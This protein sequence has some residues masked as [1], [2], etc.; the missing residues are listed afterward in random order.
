MLIKPTTQFGANKLRNRTLGPDN[1]DFVF[2]AVD[3]RNNL[4]KMPMVVAQDV[5]TAA[6]LLQGGLLSAE[7]L[8]YSIHA[9]RN[10]GL[11]PYGCNLLAAG[12]QVTVNPWVQSR[13]LKHLPFYECLKYPIVDCLHRRQKTAAV[14]DIRRF[15]RARG[16]DHIKYQEA[17]LFTCG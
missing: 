16:A 10:A 9:H 17:S 14:F 8:E 11:K 4:V 12:V 3:A 1:N 15:S 7:I 13:M 6:R 2:R 5:Y